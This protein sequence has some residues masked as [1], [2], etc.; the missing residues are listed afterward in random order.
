MGVNTWC[1]DTKKWIDD[2]A[3]WNTV[4]EK[5]KN[6]HEIQSSGLQKSAS[7]GRMLA[8]QGIALAAQCKLLMAQQGKMKPVQGKPHG[9]G[10]ER[11][12]NEGKRGRKEEGGGG[13]KRGRG[14]G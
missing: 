3:H 4:P 1:E 11:E 8:A 7:Q 13:G 12:E 5:V 14:S 10:E 6:Y 2:E 9:K